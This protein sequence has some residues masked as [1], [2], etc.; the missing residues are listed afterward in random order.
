MRANLVI[1]CCASAILGMACAGKPPVVVECSG[2]NM[3]NAATGPALVGQDYG[4]RMIPIPLDAVQYTDKSIAKRVAV[5]SMYAQRNDANNVSVGARFVNCSNQSVALGVRTSF[6]DAKQRPTEASSAWKMVYVPPKATATYD[7]I[8]VD[9]DRVQ[10]YLI[11]VRNG[12][13]AQ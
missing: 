4:A 11:E 7:E 10:H 9:R 5:Q 6:M 3:G 1:A 2:G 13:Q 12:S 8:S